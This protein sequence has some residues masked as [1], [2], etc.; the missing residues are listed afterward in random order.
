M[1]MMLVGAGAVGESILKIIQSR[2]DYKSWLEFVLVADYDL[3]RAEEVISH[4]RDR[5]DLKA[6]KVDARNE[7]DIVELIEVYDIDFVMDAAAPFVSNNI[8]D[9]AYEAG[10]NYG[11]MGTWSVPMEHPKLGLGIENSYV[12]PMTKYNFD[13]HDK[14]REKNQMACICMGIDPGVVNVFAKYAAEYEFDE[15][16]EVH[17]KDGGNLSIPGAKEGEVTFG[18]NV[19]TVLD[20]VMNPNVEYNADKG[21][22]I[23]EDAFAGEE[24]FDMPDGVG[25][26]VLVKVEHEEVVTMQRYLSKYGLKKATFKISLDPALINALKVIDSLGLRSLHPVDVGGVKVVPRDVVAAVAPQ[27]KDIGDEMKGEMLVGVHCIGI[28][29]GKKKEIFMYQPFDNQQSMKDWHMQAVVAQTG[30]GAALSIELIGKEIW[31]DSGVFSPE[32]FDPMPYLDLMRETGF[33]YRILRK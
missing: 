7:K 21:G 6:V 5:D 33:E 32:Y 19:W 4:L 20:E 10:A 16:Q 27:P 24:T 14:W 11:S 15:L 9:A 26:N 17:V 31:K 13:R 22:F 29:D 3:D 18:F 30:F 23:V 12:E 28:K 8:F 2:Q 25:K 1:R